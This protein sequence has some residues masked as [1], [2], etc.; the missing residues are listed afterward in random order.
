[1]REIPLCWMR[2]HAAGV[3]AAIAAN[4]GVSVRVVPVGE[5]RSALRAQGAYLT[6]PERV[7]HVFDE[8]HPS[9]RIAWERAGQL[10]L[11]AGVNVSVTRLP[12]V[13]DTRNQG[14]ITPLIAI[15]REKGAAAYVGEGRNRWSAAH[16]SDVALLY[17]LAIEAAE[18]SAR[19]NAVAEEGIELRVI[20]G[21]LARGLR[22]PLVVVPAERVAEQFGWMSIF[23]GMD[24]PAS[25]ALTRRKLR[26]TPT[27][28]GLIADLDA[29][30]YE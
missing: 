5:L 13:H 19:Y 29:M 18:A 15:F 27:G 20:A 1:M 23:A 6:D 28:P 21:T 14:L 24:L 11:D 22:L 9:T 2:G 26:W 16:L 4:R 17:G 25:S 12:Q 8:S 10:L 7:A 3:D 30:R